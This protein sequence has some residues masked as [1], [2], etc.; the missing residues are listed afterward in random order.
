MIS[1]MKIAER[2]GNIMTRCVTVLAANIPT[3]AHAGADAGVYV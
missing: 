1:G 3:K 2:M